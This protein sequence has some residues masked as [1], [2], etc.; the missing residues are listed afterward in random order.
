ME[1]MYFNL[2][3]GARYR[4]WR[5]LVLVGC[6]MAASCPAMG[7]DVIQPGETLDLK[8]CIA[9]ALKRHP[10]ILSASGDLAASRSRIMQARSA[11]YPQ[12]GWSTEASRIHP[13]GGT[14]ARTSDAYY[15]Q[16]ASHVDLNQTLFDF[17][18]TPAQVGVRS[19]EAQATK[20]DLDS[21]TDQIVFQAAQAYYG[22]LWAEQNR[23]AYAQTVSRFEQH[24]HSA[25]TFFEVGVRSKIDLTKA[26]VDLSQAR[27]NLLTAENALKMAVLTLKNAIGA[28]EAPD[29][30]ISDS[31]LSLAPV[32][33]QEEALA[34]ALRQRSDLRSAVSR[35]EAAERAL[36][37]A[38]AAYYPVLNGNAA[39]G[40]SGED[41]PLDREWTIGAGLSIPLFNGFQTRGQIDE[42]RAHLASARANE[43]L[44]R[45][46]VRFDIAL[47][48]ANLSNVKQR[49]TL[50]EVSLGQA[51]ENRDLAEG[52]YAAGV[53]SAL[54]VTDAVVAEVTAKTAAIS[55]RY[56]YQIA[57]AGLARAMGERLE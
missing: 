9:I 8:R 42:A 11:Y 47:A 56:D 39:Y 15:S 50:T 29:F 2:E 27:L 20:A 57:L 34:R 49:L 43:E 5:K 51:Q 26:E 38:R 46:T 6:V 32:V 36:D 4:F 33:S 35:R 23:E 54:E 21:V 55:A 48:Y 19:L 37:L 12:L 22:L 3:N 17:G 16:Y 28:P 45:Q 13:A 53:G 41:F 10:S 52:R 18:K 30:E 25:R 24:L 7:Q 40:W 31:P 14:S 44:A 1:G